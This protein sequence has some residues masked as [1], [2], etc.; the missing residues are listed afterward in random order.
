[1]SEPPVI[2]E[3]QAA[4]TGKKDM[5]LDLQKYVDQKVRVKFQGGREGTI[6]I[7]ESLLSFSA[8]ASSGLVAALPLY[9]F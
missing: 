8:R 4:P 1:M 2:L 7:S 5:I 9:L 3:S 6:H